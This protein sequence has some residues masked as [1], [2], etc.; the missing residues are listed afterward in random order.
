[1][2]GPKFCPM[3]NFRDVDWDEITR[4]VEERRRV[5]AAVS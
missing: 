4:I 3:H 2:C 1:M 5:P